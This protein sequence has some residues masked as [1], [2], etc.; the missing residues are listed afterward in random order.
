ML[1]VAL[2]TA[3]SQVASAGLVLALLALAPIGVVWCLSLLKRM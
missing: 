2:H 1:V 3:D